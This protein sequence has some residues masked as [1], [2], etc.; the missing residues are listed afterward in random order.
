MIRQTDSTDGHQCVVQDRQEEASLSQ[1]CITAAVSVWVHST[2]HAPCNRKGDGVTGTS[3]ARVRPFS[4]FAVSSKHFE[5]A[6]LNKR[7]PDA[8]LDLTIKTSGNLF[9]HVSAS[10]HHGDLDGVDAGVGH[11]IPSHSGADHA[12]DDAGG[13]PR[14][15]SEFTP[16]QR[17]RHWKWKQRLF[18]AISSIPLT[19]PGLG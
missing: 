17:L 16:R 18:V 14:C 3:G 5:Q 8:S 4:F 1:G 9:S 12:V 10:H 13:N 19:P 15:G 7:N 6:K 2:R 11:Q